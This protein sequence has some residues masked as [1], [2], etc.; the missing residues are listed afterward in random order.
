MIDACVIDASV[1]IKLFVVEEGSTEA[2]R[3]FARL[4][5]E[6][7]AQFYAPDLFFVEC[8][9]ILWKYVRNYGYPTENARKDVFDL[10]SL[11][12][13]T[14]STADLLS[15]A[16]ELAVS[17]DIAVYEA[18]YSALAEQLHLPLITADRTLIK[19]ML[20]SGVTIL[21]LEETTEI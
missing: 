7:P 11:N 13:L 21:T 19:K 14:V 9:N 1:G 12:I 17:F 10:Q 5:E 3:L 8:A 2:D 4:G 20:G 6:P 18:C 15:A 16:L